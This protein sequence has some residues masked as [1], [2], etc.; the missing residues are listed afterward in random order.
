M[1]FLAEKFKIWQFRFRKELILTFSS[2]FTSPLST[3]GMVIYQRIPDIP[4]FS[5]ESFLKVKQVFEILLD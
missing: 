2:I 3:G 5:E 1:M 4:V